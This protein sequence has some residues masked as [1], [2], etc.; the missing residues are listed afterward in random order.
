MNKYEKGGVWTFTLQ[1]ELPVSV[2]SS[3]SSSSDPVDQ[4]FRTF[5]LPEIPDSLSSVEIFISQ[6]AA[7]QFASTASGS[8]LFNIQGFVQATNQVR[9]VTLQTWLGHATW[10]RVMT[11]LNTDATYNALMGDKNS[12]RVQVHG[13]PKKKLAGR[14]RKV[15][16]EWRAIAGEAA[17]ADRRAVASARTLRFHRRLSKIIRVWA[18]CVFEGYHIEISNVCSSHFRSVGDMPNTLSDYTQFRILFGP[19]LPKRNFA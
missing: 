1:V 16:S 14:P 19:F 10:T 15:F 18:S 12:K 13:E 4:A 8:I 2:H 11:K 6:D 7:N 3:S 17:R 5:F 9:A